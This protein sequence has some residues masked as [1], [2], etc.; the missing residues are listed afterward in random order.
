VKTIVSITQINPNKEEIKMLNLFIS[1]IIAAIFFVNFVYIVKDLQ[2]G[3][4][5]PKAKITWGAVMAAY[6]T[7]T[8]FFHIFHAAGQI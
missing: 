5:F 7:F 1:P 8:L 3:S 6:L 2:N 4:R